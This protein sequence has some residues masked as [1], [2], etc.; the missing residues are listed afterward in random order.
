MRK[1]S[2]SFGRGWALATLAALAVLIV[3]ARLHTFDEPLEPDLVTYSTIGHEMLGGKRLYSDVW[4]VKPPGLYVTYAAAEWLVGHGAPSV[5]LMNIVFALLTLGGVYV[6]GSAF[7]TKAGLWAAAFWAASSGILTIQAN[8]PNAEVFINAC[9]IWGFALVLKRPDRDR[10]W[11]GM[12]G[13][14]ALFALGSG[15]KQVPVLLAAF[16]MLAH[17]FAPPASVSKKTAVLDA[18]LAASVGVAFWLSVFG[19]AALTGQTDVYWAAI[20]EAN[21]GRAAGIFFN[22]YRYIREGK[23]LPVSLLFLW[24]A[25]LF[26]ALALVRGV[27]RGPRRAWFLQL[28][29]VF[30]AHA[31]VFTQGGAFHRHSYQ[32]WLPSLAVGVGWLAVTNWFDP[33]R[34]AGARRWLGEALAAL[35]LAAVLLHELPNYAK[36]PD[37]WAVEKFGPR[38]LQDRKYSYQLGELLRPDEQVFLFGNGAAPYYYTG[39]RPTTISLWCVHLLLGDRL[40]DRLGDKTLAQLKAAPPEL[41]IVQFSAESLLKR[42]PR[43]FGFA[44]NWLGAKNLLEPSPYDT[45]PIY[46]WA[47]ANYRPWPDARFANW[48][49]TSVYLRKGSPLEQRLGSGTRATDVDSAARIR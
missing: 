30:G 5:F 33:A 15:F 46:A 1:S 24:P 18:A 4:D 36:T 48:S 47:M 38:V 20:V 42:E 31:M 10:P 7:G 23:V 11:L 21:Q 13:V 8:Q 34:A 9:C 6:A 27:V 40:A 45:H 12:L 32:L 25:I 29:F 22:L 28:A 26:T 44:S 16:L 39:R 19:Y 2:G 35:S 41:F 49:E 37:Q 3:V 43:V 14:G 17:L